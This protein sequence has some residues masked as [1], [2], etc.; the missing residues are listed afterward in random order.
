MRYVAHQT[1]GACFVLS[2]DMSVTSRLKLGHYQVFHSQV[3]YAYAYKSP[4]SSV[5]MLVRM[6]NIMMQWPRK[7]FRTLVVLFLAAGT[8]R[9]L[10]NTFS[11]SHLRIEW[12]K[13]P[14]RSQLMALA[15]SFGGPHERNT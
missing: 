8:V 3:F 5:G 7:I 10:C 15:T 9:V 12:L 14:R 13:A 4:P 1:H 6:S 11:S 2:H